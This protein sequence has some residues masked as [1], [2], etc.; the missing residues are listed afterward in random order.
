[1]SLDYDDKEMAQ[2][3]ATAH[4]TRVAGV[5]TLISYEDITDV[6][7]DSAR[8]EVTIGTATTK[9]VMPG[10]RSDRV[11]LLK[12]IKASRQD[13]D[14]GDRL[15][16]EHVA[17][18]SINSFPQEVASRSGLER[19]TPTDEPLQRFGSNRQEEAW[20]DDPTQSIPTLRS[21]WDAF[22]AVAFFAFLTQVVTN[23]DDL[24]PTVRSL[25][26]AVGFATCV[27]AALTKASFGDDSIVV[28]NL[29]RS[30]RIRAASIESF[31]VVYDSSSRRNVVSIRTTSEKEVLVRV[32][33]SFTWPKATKVA[34]SFNRFATRHR[35]KSSVHPDHL[36][37]MLTIT[38]PRRVVQAGVNL[39]R[40]RTRN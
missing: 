15:Y 7:S 17:S 16:E 6:F 8:N 9:I 4:A 23:T 26:L 28:R 34:Q 22:R 19:V 24:D 29:V 37:P 21:P 36:R 31:C 25:I 11:P 18:K 10:W 39:R 35:I 13:P 1:M 33:M 40:L 5:M 27:R 38:G 3:V 12:L 2:E 20:K 32:A 14:E 30:R